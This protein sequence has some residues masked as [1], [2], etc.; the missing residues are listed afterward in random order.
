MAFWTDVRDWLGGW[1]MDF[2]SL[3]ETQ[4][5]CRRE[6]GLTLVNVKTGQGCTEY[7]FAD[8]RLSERW[9]EIETARGLIPLTGPFTHVGGLHYAVEL[10]GLEAEA[11]SNEAPQRSRL[12]LYEDGVMLGLAHSVH[13]HIARFGGGRFS[14]WG[15]TLSFSS[16][17]GSDPNTN[18]RTYAYC[19][20]F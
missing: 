14:H 10:P 4:A 16:S 9:A 17:D 11:D 1:P 6:F 12:M 2:A 15:R 5:F 20:R 3:A 13:A 19:E 7:V 8:P 18:G